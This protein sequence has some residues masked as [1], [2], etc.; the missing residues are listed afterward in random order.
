MWC[1]VSSPLSGVG[2]S[3]SCSYIRSFR[4]WNDQNF[5]S[6]LAYFRAKT[7]T[8]LYPLVSTLM[9]I[10]LVST[11]SSYCVHQV[12]S[13]RRHFG[14]AGSAPCSVPAVDT[15]DGD[16]SDGDDKWFQSDSEG[17]DVRWGPE[18]TSDTARY[19]EGAGYRSPFYQD[20]VYHI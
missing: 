4:V 2:Q 6:L 13:S 11:A 10:Y 18:Y 12:S 15:V 19:F 3:L 8:P 16:E 5:L 14:G 7:D 17:S 9:F 20:E 1:P